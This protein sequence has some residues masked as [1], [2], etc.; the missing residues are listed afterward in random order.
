AFALTDSVLCRDQQTNQIS[1]ANS[2]QTRA[3][4]ANEINLITW[5]AHKYADS[6]YFYDVKNLS[7]NADIMMI[8]EAMHSDGW[9]KAFASH[10]P[11]SYSFYKSF[12]DFD[13]Q[14]N[15]VMTAARYPLQNSVTITSPG[16]EPGSFTHKVSGYSVVQI[17][18]QLVHLINTHALNFNIGWAFEEQIDQ[19]TKLIAQLTG[20]VIWAGDFNT[21]SPGRK[22]YLNLSAATLGLTHVIPPNDPRNLVLDHIYVRGFTASNT[23]V[24]EINSSDHFPMR[25]TLKFK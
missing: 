11:L 12:C 8:Q 16:T 7:V 6:Q 25:T 21:W 9:E 19:I 4:D 14:A 10:M 13:D 2:V 3:A 15:G 22:E 20:P 5:N 24:L 1:F 23:E 17:N 18:N